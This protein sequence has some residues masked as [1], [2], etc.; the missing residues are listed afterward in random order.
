MTAL[1][2]QLAQELTVSPAQIESA[3]RLIDDGASVPFIA[4]YRKEATGGLDEAQLRQLESR[5]AYLRDLYERRAKVLESVRSQ[6]RLTP[7]LQAR[8]EAAATKN[9]LEELYAPYR[10][11]KTSKAGQ[12]REAGLAPVAERVRTETIDP[13]AALAGFSHEQYPDLSSQLEALQHLIIEEWATD[14]P[15]TDL[16]RQQFAADAVLKSKLA[17]E[18]KREVGKKFRDYLTAA[19]PSPKLPITACWPCCVAVRKMSSP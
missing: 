8:I 7:E 2:Q 13:A 19:N 17:S 15:L 5:L 12:A 9:A 10:P 16:L 11:R 18:E 6:G 14:L 4:R 1:V 3:I